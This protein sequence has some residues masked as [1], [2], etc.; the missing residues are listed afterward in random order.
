[1]NRIPSRPQFGLRAVSAGLLTFVITACAG[2]GG[3]AWTYAPLGPTPD[4]NASA[5]PGPS[6]TP[7]ASPGLAIDVETPQEDSL[8]FV[9]NTLEAPAATTVQVNYNNNSNLPHNINFFAGSDNT[10][11]SIG[12]TPVV[13]GP[14]APESVT[15]TTPEQPGDYFFWCDVH[16]QAMAGTLTVE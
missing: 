10:A 6:G 14:N 1:M 11:P 15:I 9:P 12:A 5:T 3:A 8:A 7:G 13:T 4:P 16:L 2:G